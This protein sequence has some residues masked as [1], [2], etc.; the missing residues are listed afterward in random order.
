MGFIWKPVLTVGNMLRME[1][2]PWIGSSA[3]HTLWMNYPHEMI[4]LERL[5]V[6][7]SCDFEFGEF[8]FDDHTCDFDIG[9]PVMTSEWIQFKTADISYKD[10]DNKDGIIVDRLRLPFEC[11]VVPKQAYFQ[12]KASRIDSKDRWHYSYTGMHIYLKRDNLGKLLTGYFMLTG[13]FSLLS[14]FSFTISP[15]VVS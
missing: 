10:G 1:K 5:H 8:P 9:D 13:I 7:V 12:S 6:S 2:V 15:D 14:A 3:M 11:H 4:F